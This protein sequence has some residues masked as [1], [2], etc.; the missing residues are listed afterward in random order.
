[1]N[2]KIVE[3]DEDGIQII[4][5][6]VFIAALIGSIFILSGAAQRDNAA[7]AVFVEEVYVVKPGDTVWSIAEEYLP[8]N[9]Y[10]RRYILEYVEG[11]KENN[12]WLVERKS[13]LQPG[14]ELVMTYWVKK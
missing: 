2:R 7:D 6:F 10:S 4:M 3:D 5:K 13:Q 9:T 12:P 8:K 11:I 14:D 1:M